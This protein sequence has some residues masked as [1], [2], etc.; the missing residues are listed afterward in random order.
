MLGLI[1]K[2]LVLHMSAHACERQKRSLEFYMQ[3]LTS[4]LYW[5]TMKVEQAHFK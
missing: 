4:C 2:H 5:T 1:N 3:T